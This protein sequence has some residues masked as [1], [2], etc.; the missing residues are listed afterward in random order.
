VIAELSFSIPHYQS[1][2]WR[3]DIQ[4]NIITIFFFFFAL[5]TLFFGPALISYHQ[6]SSR[7]RWE[8]ERSTDR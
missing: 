6:R 1:L 8:A 7:S 4:V 2:E 5:L 3:L